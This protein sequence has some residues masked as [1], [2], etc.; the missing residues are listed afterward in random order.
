MFLRKQIN[1]SIVRKEEKIEVSLHSQYSFDNTYLQLQLA[2]NSE[3]VAYLPKVFG[4]IIFNNKGLVR[5][6]PDYEGVDVTILFLKNAKTIKKKQHA[7]TLVQVI[8]SVHDLEYIL[9]AVN[10]INTV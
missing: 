8:K 1:R 4:E 2:H 3:G 5:V 10:G 7:N 6:L 9:T